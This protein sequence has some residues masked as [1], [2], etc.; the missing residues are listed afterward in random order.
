MTRQPQTEPGF[1]DHSAGSSRPH[2]GESIVDGRNMPGLILVG[3]AVI[4]VAATLS[5]AAAGSLGL[6]I[7]GGLI[8]VICLLAGTAWVL[9]EHLRVKHHEGLGFHD[10]TAH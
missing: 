6:A 8:T 4:G 3:I 7:V 2:A 10:H 5:A 9:G 1:P